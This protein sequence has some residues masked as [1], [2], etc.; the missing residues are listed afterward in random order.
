[1]KMKLELSNVGFTMIKKVRVITQ[2]SCHEC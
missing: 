2:R 1:M